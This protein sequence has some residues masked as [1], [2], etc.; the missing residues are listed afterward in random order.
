MSEEKPEA[1]L[2]PEALESIARDLVVKL[3]EVE[4]I[5]SSGDVERAVKELKSVRAELRMLNL[6]RSYA[7]IIRKISRIVEEKMR[8]AE[9]KS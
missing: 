7:S 1:K 5:A 4:K 2:T 8:R 6:E 9:K 3:R